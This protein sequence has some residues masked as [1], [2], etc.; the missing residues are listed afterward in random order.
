MDSAHE[1]TEKEINRLS[2]RLGR[3]YGKSYREVKAEYEKALREFLKERSMRL[4]ALDDTQEAKAAYETWLR[5]QAI[6]LSH[7]EAIVEQLAGSLT[8]ADLEARQIA[9]GALVGVYVKNYNLSVKAIEA[10]LVGKVPEG[11]NVTFSLVD[12]PTVRKLIMESP[13][14]MPTQPTRWMAENLGLRSIAKLTGKQRAELMA[15]A[16]GWNKRHVTNAVMQGIMQGDSI[17]DIAKRIGDVFM[18][19]ANAATR[20]ARTACTCAENS[21]RLDSYHAAQELGIELV[22]EWVA[23][24]DERTRDTHLEAD[25][26]Q[27][28]IG[29]PFVVGGSEL[30]EPGDPSGDPD[31]VWNCRCTMR[32]RVSGIAPNSATEM[33]RAEIE[34]E[35]ERRNG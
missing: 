13:S 14:L 15:R 8:M 28:P 23:T 22:K 10:Q 25:G 32:A 19:N 9:N 16:S 2:R 35:R 26:Q 5:A 4:A 30:M 11:F 21:G 17:K 33:H 6:R 12:V 29:E 20:Y 31:E 18:G 7:D 24:G 1:W 27:V 3:I 34:A